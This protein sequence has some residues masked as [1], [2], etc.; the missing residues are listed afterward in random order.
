MVLRAPGRLLQPR[1]PGPPSPVPALRPPRAPCEDG[2]KGRRRER[3]T[4][5]PRAEPKPTPRRTR[6]ASPAAPRRS[7]DD[8]DTAALRLRSGR[9]PLSE[10]SPRGSAAWLNRIADSFSESSAEN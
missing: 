1:T 4:G 8:H 9:S 3:E 10:Q 6:T 2:P 5:T 7:E